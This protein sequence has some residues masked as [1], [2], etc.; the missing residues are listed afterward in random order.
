MPK[1][2]YYQCIW[3]IRDIDRLEELALNKYLFENC[4]NSEVA[5]IADDT[6]DLI[7]VEII[8]EAVRRLECIHDA[9]D[10]IPEEYRKDIIDIIKKVRPYYPDTAHENTWNKWKHCFIYRL[11]KNMDMF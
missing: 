10:T 2:V 9:L 8:K 7:S 6:Q 1:E 5:F 3:M 11:A 4:S